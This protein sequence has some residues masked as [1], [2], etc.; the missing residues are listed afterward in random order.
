MSPE[1]SVTYVTIP[2]ALTAAAS[3]Q[4]Q[5]VGQDVTI[6]G[7]LTADDAPLADVPVALYNADDIIELVHVV[8]VST[9]ALG[10][11]KFNVTDS[12]PT[13]HTY[14]VRYAGDATFE[15][16]VSPELSVSYVAITAITATAS[17]QQQ[18][19]GHDV[20]ISGQLTADDAPLADAPVALHNADDVEERA[21]IAATSTD[22][23]GYYQF[24]L[25]GAAVGHPTY[26]VRYAGDNTHSSAQSPELSV[27]Y[28]GIPTAITATASPQQQYVGKDFT[29]TGQLIAEDAPL[30]DAPVALHNADDVE[31]R[32]PIAATST[33]AS[34]YYQ[35]TL[36]D[37]A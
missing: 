32:A 6:T 20:T 30:A 27:S 37:A 17:P 10:Y 19:V 5:Y 23:S 3:P 9:D 21:P 1:I 2:T 12:A 15:P 25:T 8:T 16:S 4:Q 18:Y 14:V 26:F 36:T 28:V 22:A 11:C 13:S 7:Q 24:T 33:D 34:G 31:E 29:I 35:F